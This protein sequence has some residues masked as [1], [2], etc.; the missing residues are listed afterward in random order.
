MSATILYR[1][2][3]SS[4][5]PRYAIWLQVIFVTLKTLVRN[6][7]K[8]TLVWGHTRLKCRGIKIDR[9]CCSNTVRVRCA[10]WPFVRCS[11]KIIKGKKE[12]KKEKKI[13]ARMTMLENALILLSS[14][15]RG[16]QA[17]FFFYKVDPFKVWLLFCRCPPSL[18]QLHPVSDFAA[19]GNL[20]NSFDGAAAVVSS[21]RAPAPTTSRRSDGDGLAVTTV[22]EDLRERRKKEASS[23]HLFY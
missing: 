14:T 10:S 2:L 19:G 21:R 23:A 11:Q 7:L 3:C 20:L 18:I 1:T 15:E 8:W 16:K 4:L 5:S 13:T 9:G 22:A 6:I 17:T 12:K